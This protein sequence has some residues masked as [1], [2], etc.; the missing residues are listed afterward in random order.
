MPPA[1]APRRDRTQALWRVRLG[2]ALRTILACT[3]VACTTLYGPAPLRNLLT[4]PAFSY[5]TTI[6]IVSD[7]TLG[8]ALR[9]F[10]HAL[11]ATVQVLILSVLSLRIVG[12]ARFTNGLAAVA[13]AINAFLV[14]VPESTPLISKRIAFGQIVIVYVGAVVHGAQ[15]GSFMHPVHVASSTALGAL[16][17]VLAMLFPYPH[18]AYFVERKT[19]L[20]YAE[21]GLERL[22]NLLDAFFAQNNA[23]YM[24]DLIISQ[25]KFLSKTGA[26]LLQRIQDNKEGVLWER[27]QR[28]FLK[29]S[30]IDPVEKLQLMEIPIRGMEMALANSTNTDSMMNEELR[31]VLGCLKV[32]LGQKFEQAKGSVPF[33]STTAT[34]TME[35]HLDKYLWKFQSNPITQEELPILFF[36]YCAGRLLHGSTN[37]RIPDTEE[38]TDLEKQALMLSFKRTW[39]ILDMLPTSQSLVFAFKC[40]LSLGFAVLFGLMYDKENGYWSGLTIAISFATGRQPTFAV[41]NARAQGTAMGSVY[42]I[43]CSYIF[44]RF[45]DLRLLPL[46][47]WIVFTSFLMHSRMYGQGGGISAVIGALL[48]LGRKN[49]GRP[50]EFAIARLTEACIGLICF[51]VVEILLNPARAASLAKSE[52]S[53]SLEA[54]QDWFSNMIPCHS[55]KNMRGSTSLAL[56]EKQNKLKT[57]VKQLEKFIAE[58]E[59]EPNFWFLPF[60]GS[61][62]GKLLASL[63]KM[64][65]LLTIVAYQIEFLSQVPKIFGVDIKEL[66]ESD[67]L[68]LF[69]KKVGSSLKCLKKLTSIKSLAALEKEL[70]KKIVSHDAE[71]GKSANANALRLLCTDE[72]EVDSILSSILQHLNEETDKIYANEC[73][74]QLKSQI[75]LCLS[76]LGFCIG[77]LMRETMEIEREIKE[78][79]KWENLLSHVNLNEISCKI[80]ILNR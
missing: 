7:A 2:S 24:L 51:L 56:R 31:E 43:L 3:I 16:A 28:K 14:A 32:Q 70:Q 42:G 17:S 52:L 25:A 9:G 69:K 67:D 34:E 72:Q 21:N 22:K 63:S 15:T 53:G 79:V 80:N 47:P 65:D 44:Q 57:N 5:V 39:T 10:W 6:L 62:Y 59:L 61:C 8:D 41:A 71:L 26:K 75:V 12:P 76:G 40:S 54:L 13:V 35:E 4:Y 38:S 49:Y 19:R 30:C 33:D 27:P 64:M 23:A 18:L 58:A 1:A 37:A 50:S 48:I 60:H 78:L 55:Q 29:R 74:K 46:I 36:L 73:E 77:S 68:Q 45:E 20:L 66:W 11:F